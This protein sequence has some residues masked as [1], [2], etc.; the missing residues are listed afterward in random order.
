M[1][2]RRKIAIL[3]FILCV[4]L[5]FVTNAANHDIVWKKIETQHFTICYN[6]ASKQLLQDIKRKAE[7]YYWE[8]EDKLG[9]MHQQWN[10]SIYIYD[11]RDDYAEH[12][13]AP[14]WSSGCSEFETREIQTFIDA[15][16]FLLEILPHE[17]GHL[18][19]GEYV[20]NR[21]SVPLCVNE[22]VAMF[23]EETPRRRDWAYVVN[24]Y[25][26]KGKY[27]PAKKLF[28]VTL[29]E[30][31]SFSDHELIDAFY[32]E[33]IG[34]LVFLIKRHGKANFTSFVRQLRSG[35]SPESAMR[36]AFGYFNLKDFE[37]NWLASFQ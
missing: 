2:M 33:A 12:S 28:S 5:P 36:F 7:G 11:S 18:I 26:Q 15:P 1:R 8:L 3:C 4:L 23:M 37:K 9:I 24:Y 22:G 19:F 25:T 27:M 20:E 32:A 35:D 30:L 31:N 13:G 16:N 21:D 17:L 6:Q 29:A 10:G 34:M 14:Q